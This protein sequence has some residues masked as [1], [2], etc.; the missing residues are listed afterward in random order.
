[1]SIEKVAKIVKRKGKY[2]VVGHKKDKNGKHRN[3]GCYDSMEEAK[4]RLGQIFM[5]KHKKAFF[6]NIMTTASDRLENKGIIHIADVINQCTEEF[7]T[8]VAGE[9]TA[10]KLMKVVNLLEKR[11][12][13][14][15]AE[16]I[17]SIIPEIL[18]KSLGDE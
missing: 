13:F 7:A 16:Q 1:M 17:D 14:D 6:L 15:I 9:K 3:F 4:K 5:F 11:G 10:I 8:N 2:C 18:D 12:E